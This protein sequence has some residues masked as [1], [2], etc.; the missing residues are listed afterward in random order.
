MLAM[1][2]K[3]RGGEVEKWRGGEVE[4]LSPVRGGQGMKGLAP[5]ALQAGGETVGG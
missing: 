4:R 5:L 2:Q 3:W 1:G